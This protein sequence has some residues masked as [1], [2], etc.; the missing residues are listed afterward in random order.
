LLVLAA[1]VFN[2]AVNK[3][4]RSM[5]QQVK[6]FKELQQQQQQKQQKQQQVALAPG[7]GSETAAT[8]ARTVR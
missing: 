5:M 2:P 6:A 8:L 4:R 7:A 1:G 3:L